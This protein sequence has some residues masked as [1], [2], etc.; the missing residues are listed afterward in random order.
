M[1]ESDR[2][3]SS[4]TNSSR[5]NGNGHGNGNGKRYPRGILTSRSPMDSSSVESRN[6]FRSTEQNT[7]ENK[8]LENNKRRV[9]S[10]N[11]QECISIRILENRIIIHLSYNVI[12]YQF[13]NDYN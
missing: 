6:R 8:G 3:P 12:S 9:I 1:S 5:M 10:K 11:K 13:R 4:G 2:A 7:L